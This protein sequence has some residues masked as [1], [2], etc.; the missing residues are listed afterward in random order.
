MSSKSKNTQILVASLVAAAA[1]GLVLFY[2]TS[3]KSAAKAT[4][5]TKKWDDN[6]DDGTN[7]N[8]AKSSSASSSRSVDVTPKKSNLTDCDEKQMHS[9]IEELDKKGKALF[10]NKQV[11]YGRSKMVVLYPPKIERVLT[12]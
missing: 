4:P 7:K 1:I 8:K 12:R 2:A 11:R 9:K 10:K 6:D 5:K 3:R